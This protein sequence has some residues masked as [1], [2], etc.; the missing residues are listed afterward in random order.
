MAPSL[1]GVTAAA[2]GQKLPEDLGLS[3]VDSPSPKAY[4]ISSFS[5]ILVYQEQQDATK[6]KALADFLWWAIH[7][8]QAFGATLDYAPLPK[9]QLPAIETRLKTL[10]S[11]GKPLITRK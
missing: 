6:G 11:G 10:V 2:M 4:P 8:G 1:E 5:Y 9:D 3:I 7:E